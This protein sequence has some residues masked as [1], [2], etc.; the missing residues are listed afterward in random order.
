VFDDLDPDSIYPPLPAPDEL[1][2]FFWDGVAAHRLMIQRCDNCGF[3]VHWPREVCRNCLSTSLTPAD[4]SGRGT[5]TT[6]TFP[7]QPS[8][9]WYQ[10]HLP[11]ALAVVDLVEQTGLKMVTNLVDYDRDALRIDMPVAVTFREVAPRLTLPLFAP[12]PAGA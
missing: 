7:S 4:V 11:Y 8:D 5:L 6:W 3:Y 2:R 9:P 10:T 12:A 1:T